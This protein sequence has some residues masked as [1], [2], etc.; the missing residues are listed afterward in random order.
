[1]FRLA[2]IALS[3]CL[4]CSMFAR[5][6][7]KTFMPENDLHLE[8]DLFSLYG[9]SEQEFYDVIEDAERVFAPIVER[10]GGRLYIY[11]K[12]YDS[13][14][15]AMTYRQG[16]WWIIEMYGGLARRREITRDGFN[17][18]LCHEFGH[19]LGG[20]PF[21]QDWAAAEGQS[22]YYATHACAK[23]LWA[24]DDNSWTRRQ[25]PAFPKGLCDRTWKSQADRDLCYRSM[26]ASKSTNDLLAVL[27]GERVN[28]NT[29]DRSVVRRTNT[30]YPR[31]TQ[32]RLDTMM[33]GSVC[34]ARWNHGRI[35]ST[36]RSSVYYLCST[37][38]GYSM[39]VRPRCWFAPRIGLH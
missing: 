1:M 33:A 21:V 16:D 29:P 35:P 27:S 15:N 34:V 7:V 10:L 26:L 22:D 30:S 13:T 6:N 32:C 2:I 24:N 31:T 5:T 37:A 23:L 3:F 14:V 38:R 20:F 39:G 12:W 36:E 9:T 18:V 25:I 8:D 17:M 28:Y 19:Q 4:S 11:K